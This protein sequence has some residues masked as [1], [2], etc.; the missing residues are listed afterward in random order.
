VHQLLR[1][2]MFVQLRK[3]SIERVL[4]LFNILLLLSLQDLGGELRV[5]NR[6]D[7]TFANEGRVRKKR[8]DILCR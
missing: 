4:L 7:S 2:V 6:R 8:V 1:L 3:L 5:R